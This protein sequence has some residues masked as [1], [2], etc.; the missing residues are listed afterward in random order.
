LELA[1]D[2]ASTSRPASKHAPIVHPASLVFE[3]SPEQAAAERPM[4]TSIVKKDEAR[5]DNPHTFF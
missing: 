3:S 2:V 1:S 5:A 4:P